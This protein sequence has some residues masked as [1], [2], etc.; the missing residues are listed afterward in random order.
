MSSSFPDGTGE[1]IEQQLG[2]GLR[3][4]H[5]AECPSMISRGLYFLHQ[6]V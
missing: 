5:V 6:I 1:H 4:R 3:Q 2:T